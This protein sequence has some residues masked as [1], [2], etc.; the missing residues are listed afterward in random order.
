MLAS[1]FKVWDDAFM[2][3]HSN[4]SIASTT[5]R[6]S[7]VRDATGKALHMIGAIQDVSKLLEMEKKME[8]QA[9]LQ[10]EEGEKF[11][12]AAK[13]SFDVI[14]DWNI[15][16]NEVFL[17]DGFEELFGY[18]I[19]NNRANMIHDWVDKLHPDDKEAV[20]A[21]L[22]DCIKSPVTHWEHGYRVQR[23]NGTIAKV[24]VRAS[25]IRHADGKAYRM[26]G[27]MQDLSRQ[28]E[29]EEKLE[30]EIVLKER[31][32]ADAAKDAKEMER[33]DI[34]K[35][36]HDNINQLLGASKMYIEM[37]KRGGKNIT[38]YL[39]RSSEYM[40]A[41]I[42][43]IRK[44]TKG[45]T[46]DIIKNLGLCDAIDN[47]ARD[48]MEV[49]P[50]KISLATHSFIENSVNDK[51]KLNVLRIIQEQL[52]NIM[53]HAKASKV[54]INLIQNKKAIR[55]IIA[56]NGTGF[57]TTKFQEGIGI[58]N[59]KSRAA[60]YQGTAAFASEPGRGCILTA[61]FPF[62]DKLLNQEKIAG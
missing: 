39:S 29:L 34:G 40:I 13:L 42:D 52:N 35:E 9:Q 27:A 31:Q 14:W 48:T 3:K 11:L 60:A 55:L 44:L 22:Q 32:I 50:V 15:V 12:L 45:L 28:K 10:D 23:A 20:V 26:I 4:G 38:M 53:K 57:N 19:E 59:I 18:K 46:T 2:F 1:S 17:G 58:P 43:E 54:S 8:L 25:I 21:E 47:I 5:S 49:S 41:A 62:T 6:A 51:F 61:I 24:Y 16:T 30:A 37:A 33:A 36:L 56:D 7:I